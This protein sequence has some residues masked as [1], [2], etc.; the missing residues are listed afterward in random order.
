M[1]KDFEEDGQVTEEGLDFGY[2]QLASPSGH[3]ANPYTLVNLIE[4]YKWDNRYWV[5]VVVESELE[6]E[7][8]FTKLEDAREY[9]W[10]RAKE[11]GY[12]MV[13]QS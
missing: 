2:K 13:I 3:K 7:E 6:D 8:R 11:L 10:K 12:Q 1:S 9:F 4:L 5:D